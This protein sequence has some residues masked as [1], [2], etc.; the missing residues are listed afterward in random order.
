MGVSDLWQLLKSEG[1]TV[2]WSS[3]TGTHPLIVDDVEATAIAVDLSTWVLQATSQPN[4]V[5]VYNDPECRAVI[6]AFNR[7]SLQAPQLQTNMGCQID[8]CQ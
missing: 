6:V 1:V 3:K 4:L 5:E 2:S 7:V 8:Q